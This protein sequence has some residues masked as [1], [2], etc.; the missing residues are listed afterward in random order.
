MYQSRRPIIL[1][2]QILQNLCETFDPQENWFEQR[3]NT[4]AC[5]LSLLQIPNFWKIYSY[6]IGGLVYSLD[7]IEHGVLRANKGNNS[8]VGS[9]TVIIVTFISYNCNEY[10][11][12]N[13]DHDATFDNLSLWKNEAILIKEYLRGNS[14]NFCWSEE[15]L[16]EPCKPLHLFLKCKCR[17]IFVNC[18]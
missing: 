7:D 11:T 6:D 10:C 5:D 13:R 4:N 17:L 12:V 9:N 8:A 3:K 15:N 18:A 1:K 14:Y 16:R 2:R